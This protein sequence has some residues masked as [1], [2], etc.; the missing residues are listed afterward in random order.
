MHP[1]W[2]IWLICVPAQISA[3]LDTIVTIAREFDTDKLSSGGS[4][5]IKH[6]VIYA[7]RLY[8]QG[9]MSNEVPIA[10]FMV[11]VLCRVRKTAPKPRILICAP[12]NAAADEL[13][14]RIMNTGFSDAQ[15]RC[16]LSKS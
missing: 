4:A 8:L 15:V 5:C 1:Q 11:S 3:Y 14:Q 7:F 12:S 13:L 6:V 2:H 10:T 9:Y 16:Q